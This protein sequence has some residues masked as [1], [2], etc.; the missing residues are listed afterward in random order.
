VLLL[1]SATPSRRL[2]TLA[3]CVACVC[4]AVLLLASVVEARHFHSSANRDAQRCGVCA[5]GHS[6]TLLARTT[7]IVPE[8]VAHALTQPRERAT[9]SA[10]SL[11]SHFIRPPPAPLSF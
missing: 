10:I 9:A 8:S 11:E 7:P 2:Q 1:T 5:V 3:V 6:P 4:V